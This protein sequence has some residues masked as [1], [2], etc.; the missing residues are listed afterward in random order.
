VPEPGAARFNSLEFEGIRK[1]DDPQLCPPY[2]RS[3]RPRAPST[4][5]RSAFFFTFARI[6]STK[7]NPILSHNSKRPIPTSAT[8]AAIR[9]RVAGSRE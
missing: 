9:S 5:Y 2:G 1:P 6:T 7:S 4:G 8:S 3:A